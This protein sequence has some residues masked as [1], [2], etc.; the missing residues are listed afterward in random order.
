MS[1]LQG[2]RRFLKQR[3]L[4]LLL[5]LKVS[6]EAAE[7]VATDVVT[8]SNTRTPL[9]TLRSMIVDSLAARN[10]SAGKRLAQLFSK[11]Q[12]RIARQDQAGA[13]SEEDVYGEQNLRELLEDDEITAA[14]L[15]FMEGRFGHRW[16]SGRSHRDSASVETSKEDYFED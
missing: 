12:R 10:P 11:T 8:R 16:K 7:G 5:K 14:E 4:D 2:K 3:I 1:E 9:E 13:A 6:A 15:F